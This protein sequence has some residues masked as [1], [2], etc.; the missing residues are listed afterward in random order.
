MAAGLVKRKPVAQAGRRVRASAGAAA[1]RREEQLNAYLEAARAKIA[2]L[3]AEALRRTRRPHD[4]GGMQVVSRRL[5]PQR[6]LCRVHHLDDV[7]RKALALAADGLHERETLLHEMRGF[8]IEKNAAF[9]HWLLKV[10]SA[11]AQALHWF[12]R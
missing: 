4:L 10:S 2:A 6:F 3:K 1:F 12:S 5:P 7:F 11:S 8:R 9:H